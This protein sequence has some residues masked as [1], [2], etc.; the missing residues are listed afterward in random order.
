MENTVIKNV[1][2]EKT[3]KRIIE[4]FKYLGFD[5]T[6][7]AATV[8]EENE[9]ICIYYGVINGIFNNYSLREVQSRNAKIIEL[10]EV[11]EPKRGDRV[12]VWDDNESKACERIFLTEI[13][14]S[15]HPFIIIYKP[16]EKKFL[17]GEKFEFMAYKNIKP[18]QEVKPQFVELTIEDISNGKGVGVP[19][20]L[21][22]IKK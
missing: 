3:G 10:P 13:K 8:S 5:T 11:F 14:G 6:E 20:E 16:D 9:N 15:Y 2:Y 1:S 12:L 21:I 7:Y 4:Y 22:I 19:P 17:N 18:I